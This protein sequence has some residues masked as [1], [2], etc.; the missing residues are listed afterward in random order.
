M[1]DHT[2]PKT[3]EEKNAMSE[4]EGASERKFAVQCAA[5]LF[6]FIYY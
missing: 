6:E 5:Q 4:S 2:E 1:F 3:K